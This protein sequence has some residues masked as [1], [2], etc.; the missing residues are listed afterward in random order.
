[1]SAICDGGAMPV[2]VPM[3]F[4]PDSPYPSGGGTLITV[5]DDIMHTDDVPFSSGVGYQVGTIDATLDEAALMNA[6]TLTIAI[7]Y[8]GDLQGGEHFS[9][10]HPV[11]RHRLYRVRT[12]K[13]NGD[14]TWDITIRPGLRGDTAADT[15]LNFNTPKCVMRLA[16]GNA[17]DATFEGIGISR[18]T[19][20]FIEAFPPFPE[21]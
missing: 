17:M 21:P 19:V 6:T 18:P 9:I 11:L 10:D 2:V 14:G 20:M 15:K 8:G 1:M 4:A 16:A 3:R 5:Y 7:T 13:D 12:A